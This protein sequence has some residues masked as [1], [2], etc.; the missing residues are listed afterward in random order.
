MVFRKVFA[1]YYMSD[2][3]ADLLSIINPIHDWPRGPKH[4]FSLKSVTYSLQL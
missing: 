1:T 4:P 2:P 3:K